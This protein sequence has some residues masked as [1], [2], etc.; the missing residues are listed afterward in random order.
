MRWFGAYK[1][2]LGPYSV[3]M[4][5][6]GERFDNGGANRG[7]LDERAGSEHFEKLTDYQDAYLNLPPIATTWAKISSLLQ[8]AML[9]AH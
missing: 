4:A 9:S 3:G 2:L 8:S 5:Y 1:W 7:E 6:F